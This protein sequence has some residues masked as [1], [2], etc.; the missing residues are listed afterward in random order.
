MS[1]GGLSQEKIDALLAAN[2]I[3]TNLTPTEAEFITKTR[4]VHEHFLNCAIR[5]IDAI[6]EKYSTEAFEALAKM[7]REYIKEHKK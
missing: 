2:G 7:C 1:D 4:E 3:H 5:E 6:I